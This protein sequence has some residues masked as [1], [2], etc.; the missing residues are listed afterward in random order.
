[1]I[2]LLPGEGRQSLTVFYTVHQLMKSQR[3]KS[4]LTSETLDKEDKVTQ[5][6]FCLIYRHETT[7]EPSNNS[8]FFPLSLFS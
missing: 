2:S 4:L 8:G 1:M 5:A 7:E 3:H 6:R